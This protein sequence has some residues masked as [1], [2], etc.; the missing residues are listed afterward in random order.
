VGIEECIEL[1]LGGIGDAAQFAL[2]RIVH[3]VIEGIAAPRFREGTANRTGEA[4]ERRNVG[5]VE[6]KRDGLTTHRL[7]FGDNGTGFVGSGAIGQDHIP[8]MA[9]NADSRVAAKAAAAAGNKRNSGH[10]EV[11]GRSGWMGFPHAP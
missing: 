4:L 5:D 7:D 2:S 3:K 9:G 6:L 1:R 8:A 11:P 10:W